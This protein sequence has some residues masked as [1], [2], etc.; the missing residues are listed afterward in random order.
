[1]DFACAEM[2]DADDSAAHEFDPLALG[3]GESEVDGGPRRQR[4]RPVGLVG[5]FRSGDMDVGE[6]VGGAADGPDFDSVEVFGVLS[7]VDD[8]DPDRDLRLVEEEE[9]AV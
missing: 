9:H 1:M 8:V 3:K 5:T 6:T 7:L 4:S 2:D